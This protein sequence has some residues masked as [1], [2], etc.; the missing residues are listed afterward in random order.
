MLP[1]PQQ[2]PPPSPTYQTF[3]GCSPPGSPGGYGIPPGQGY[4]G[5]P[6]PMQGM[7]GYGGGG[8]GGNVLPPGWEM[9][10]DPNGRTMYVD[11][12]T[13]VRRRNRNSKHFPFCSRLC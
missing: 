2:Q 9:R 12:N 7:P 5:A 1:Q 6:P 13:K 10:T 11:H 3:G 4:Q 8:G